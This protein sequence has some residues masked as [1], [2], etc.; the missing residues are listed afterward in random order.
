MIVSH[1][2]WQ[3]RL[4]GRADAIGQAVRLD[5]ADYTL[6]GV[7]PP[8]VGPLEQRIEWF[9]A[10]AVPAA[11]AARAVS[12]HRRGPAAPGSGAGGRGGGAARDQQEH[13]PD[14]EELVPGRQGDVG[15]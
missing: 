7:L 14:L 11:A 3:Q 10:A 5:G 9:V 6:A 4:G 1:G 2:F 12:V 8:K 15:E 13:L